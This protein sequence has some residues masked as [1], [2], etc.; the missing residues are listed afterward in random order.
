VPVEAP[1]GS[2]LSFLTMTSRT[3]MD[4]TI[5]RLADAIGDHYGIDR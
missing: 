1:S 5:Q 4:D 2:V 3:P